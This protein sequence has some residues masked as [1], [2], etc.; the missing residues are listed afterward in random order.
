MLLLSTVKGWCL[1]DETELIRKRLSELHDRALS[2]NI[3]VF[4]DFLSLSEQSELLSLRLSDTELFGGYEAA[5]RKI[6]CFGSEE[7]FGYSEVPP[8]VCVKIEP[9]NKKFSDK[10]THR[11]FLGSVMA[12]G[13]ERSVIGDIILKDNTA[14]VLCRDTIA[15]YISSAVK[16]VRHTTVRCCVSETPEFINEEPAVVSSVVASERLDAVIAGVWSVSRAEGKKLVE[17]GKV[18]LDGRV[19]ESPSAQIKQGTI[20]SVR[21]TGRFKYEGIEKETRRGRLK[22]SFRKY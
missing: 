13:I 16:S 1:M 6:A 14:W 15:D 22:V 7:S 4:S 5:E 9:L 10:L 12:A 8:I 3:W 20:V 11:D 18:F 19:C 17:S 21:G 2:R